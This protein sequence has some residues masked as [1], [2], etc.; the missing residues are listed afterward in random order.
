MRVHLCV[1]ACV[2]ACMCVITNQKVPGLR[3][4]HANLVLLLLLP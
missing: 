4:G 1:C 2:R 3:P